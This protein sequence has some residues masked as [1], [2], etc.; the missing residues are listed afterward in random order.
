MPQFCLRMF[1]V[2]LACA[3]GGLSVF[4]GLWGRG[5]SPLLAGAAAAASFAG[6]CLTAAALLWWRRYRSTTRALEELGRRRGWV[7]RG[8]R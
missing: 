2:G 7:E 6:W 8:A 3:F 4:A 1:L 5:A